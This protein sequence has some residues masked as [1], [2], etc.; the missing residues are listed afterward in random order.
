MDLFAQELISLIPYM[1]TCARERTQ[2]PCDA[3]DLVQ[4]AL[5][6][7][8]NSR[9]HYKPELPMKYWLA[10]IIR[11]CRSTMHRAQSRRI[12]TCELEEGMCAG[13]S[14]GQHECIELREMFEALE[15][16]PE[17]QQDT[18]VS[19]TFRGESYRKLAVRFDVE[20]G[21]IRSRISR[22]RR[23]LESTF[24]VA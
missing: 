6:C 20:I 7:A 12:S 23:H 10:G 11:N 2:D 24:A 18:L 9:Q 16:L 22:A 21:T 17:V 3:E 4:T 14:G 13:V 1:H 15:A 5:M 8:W 19:F